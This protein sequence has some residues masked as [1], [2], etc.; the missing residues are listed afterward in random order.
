MLELVMKTDLQEAL[1]QEIGFNFE[2]LKTEIA[3]RV[4]HYNHL[5][6][7]EDTIKEAKT[8][9]A[10]L[11]KLRTAI[12]QARKDTKKVY[13][14]PYADFEAR[15]KEVT[16]L[17]DEPIKAID[18]QLLSFEE[19]RAAAKKDQVK[20]AYQE[21]IQEDIREIIPLNR[22]LDGKWIN[23]TTSMKQV[24]EELTAWNNRVNADML[25]LDTV[26]PEYKAGVKQKYIET[27]DVSK[28]IAHRDAL[29]AAEE[30]FRAREAERIAREEERRREA[31][32]RA[33]GARRK[34]A[35]L[36]AQ[37]NTQ[38]VEET[39]VQTPEKPRV[40]LVDTPKLHTLTLKFQMTRAQAEALK[41]FLD[42]QRISY[43][44]I[45]EER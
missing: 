12:D 11:N 22:I 32:M 18:T 4:D 41:E 40:E 45:E 9:R 20:Q 1:P 39:P 24:K 16:A 10:K 33:E 21:I 5:V 35:E 42:S 3:E 14:K 34:A 28:A 43:R 13:M 2:E 15:I 29:K 30:A 8:D 6:V 27:L 17:I 23:A 44:K 37:R 26:E 7:T 19:A 36:E 31:E 38:Q 25:A